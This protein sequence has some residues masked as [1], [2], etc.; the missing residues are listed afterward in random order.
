MRGKR[1]AQDCFANSFTSTVSLGS[2]AFS[3]WA[4]D[5]GHGA[6][7]AF[8]SFATSVLRIVSASA[9]T[10]IATAS[11]SANSAAVGASLLWFDEKTTS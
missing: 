4:A 9:I 1:G 2:M 3:A 8:A 5:F 7:S 11:A 10:R 6:A